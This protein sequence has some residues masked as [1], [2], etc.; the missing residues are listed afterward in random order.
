M[1]K[2]L[3]LGLLVVLIVWLLKRALGGPRKPDAATPPPQDP[4]A[5]GSA[6]QG[7]LVSCAH[8]GLNLPRGEARGAG[9]ALYCSDE[10]ARLGP[11]G[12]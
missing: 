5:G 11:G 6:T 10:H 1:T 3:V 12:K 4:A 7:D 8:C 2:L 9:G